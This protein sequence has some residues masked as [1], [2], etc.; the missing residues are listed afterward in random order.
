MK[1]SVIIPNYCHACFLKQRIDSVLQQTFDDFE[2]IILDDCST[3]NSREVIESYRSCGKVAHIV[4]NEENSGSTFVQ[5]KKGFELARGEYIWIAES[6]DFADSRF[7]E[8]CL[9]VLERESQCTV[10]YADSLYVDAKSKVTS[11]VR[12]KPG[13]LYTCEQGR[14]FVKKR[15]L[16]TNSIYNASMA[17][18]RRAA[19]PAADEYTRYRYAGDWL[20]WSQVALQGSVAHVHRDLNYFRQHEVKV[21]NNARKDGLQFSEG[22]EVVRKLFAA[23]KISW[24]RRCATA[25]SYLHKMRRYASRNGWL[26]C[27]NSYEV[28]KKDYP[29]IVAVQTFRWI[30]KLID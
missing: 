8:L 22:Y 18:F 21:S 3:D 28:W 30:Y 12:K 16:H 24:P 23:A 29:N 15:M 2:I 27:R 6:D 14:K 9:E 13:R 20:F 17:L 19:L 7:L 4:Y 11:R 10:A 1:V 5:W 25:G 26:A